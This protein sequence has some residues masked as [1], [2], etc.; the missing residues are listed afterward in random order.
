MEDG[1]STWGL[2]SPHK[3]PLAEEVP[4]LL[5]AVI[6]DFRNPQS[7]S[8]PDNV[9]S[10][11]QKF[12]QLKVTPTVDSDF[13]A[14]RNRNK[15]QSAFARLG[16]IL[17]ADFGKSRNAD[18]SFQSQIVRTHWLR[19]PERVFNAIKERHA[20]E[21]E[22]LFQKSKR[23]RVKDAAPLDRPGTLYMIVGIKTCADA[24]SSREKLQENHAILTAKVPIS[25]TIQGLGVPSSLVGEVSDPQAGFVKERAG[26]SQTSL[27]LTGERIFAIECQLVMRVSQ[28]RRTR[29]I[30]RAVESTELSGGVKMPRGLALYGG[31]IEEDDQATERPDWDE[32]DDQDLDLGPQSYNNLLESVEPGSVQFCEFENDKNAAI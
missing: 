3:L 20:N 7:D 4:N 26:R 5:G 24:L 18:E 9:E 8:V 1:Y 32:R 19:K 2:L 15:S 29:I 10:F 25:E 27:M 11:M 16:D 12:E 23:G 30:P 22:E 14:L 13:N 17:E 31:A 21:L 28:W 6:L